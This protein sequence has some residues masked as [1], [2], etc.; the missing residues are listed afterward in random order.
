MPGGR[1]AGDIPFKLC[2]RGTGLLAVVDVPASKLVVHLE[3]GILL[4]W[5]ED[6]KNACKAQFHKAKLELVTSATIWDDYEPLDELVVK[7]AKGGRWPCQLGQKLALT[8][9]KKHDPAR[10]LIFHCVGMDPARQPAGCM[11]VC[12]KIFAGPHRNLK[13]IKDHAAD[14]EH[15]PKELQE[16]VNQDLSKNA[17]LV[18]VAQMNLAGE[19]KKIVSTMELLVS[20]ILVSKTAPSIIYMVSRKTR[21]DG[22]NAQLEADLLKFA[23]VINIPLAVFDYPEWKKLVKNVDACLISTT[24][25]H[26]RDILIPQ[27]VG[28]VRTVQIK[29]LWMCE[30]LTIT[31]D[32]NTTRAPESVY[33]IH[34]IQQV[35]PSQFTGIGSDDTGNTCVAHEKVQKEYPWILN[36]AD[37]CHHLN[38]LTKDICNL[39]HF[40]GII[41]DVHRTVK[42]FKKSTIANSHLKKAHRV[43]MILCGIIVAGVAASQAPTA[44]SYQL[45]AFR[46]GNYPFN[47]LLL[48]DM[49]PM[50]WWHLLEQNPSSAVLAHCAI[51]LFAMTPNSMADEQTASVFSWI[52]APRC[53]HQKSDTIVKLAQLRSH[54]IRESGEKKPSNQPMVKFRDMKTTLFND[55][56]AGAASPN[57]GNGGNIES[58]SESDSEDE[59]DYESDVGE[60]SATDRMFVPSDEITVGVEVELDLP[61]LRD[62]LADDGPADGE[63]AVTNLS[64]PLDTGSDGTIRWAFD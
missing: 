4:K 23:I 36:M 7:K 25:C 24:L 13:W 53:S 1:Q 29:E 15:L 46:E 6:L 47:T 31:F 61:V 9:Y 55:F 44:L 3:S 33:T 8:C 16:E 57:S 56:K 28:H 49:S 5:V 22:Q 40:K 34:A 17:P 37:P 18:K 21:I 32:G 58:E 12:D 38:N 19:K 50:D 35:G 2:E 48:E 63:Q 59:S 43:H 60:S 20:S 51:K 41:K 45:H 64:P 14:C 11:T 62:L 10:K 42:F 52:N 27:E 39:P 30:N 26:I 54:Y